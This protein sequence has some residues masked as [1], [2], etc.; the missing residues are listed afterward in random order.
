M[1]A[2]RIP[3]RQI[4]AA[5]AAQAGFDAEDLLAFPSLRSGGVKAVRQRAVML[6]RHWRP[7]RT[8]PALERDFRRAHG[9]LYEA[10]GAAAARYLA[11]DPDEV[12]AVQAVADALGVEVG[13][14]DLAGPLRRHLLRQLTTAQ[15]AVVRLKSQIAAL[16]ASA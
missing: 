6:T 3:V 16:E 9:T 11:G 7:D 4:I 2:R 13:E 1:D 10:S 12:R 14:I 5:T 8:W 15:R